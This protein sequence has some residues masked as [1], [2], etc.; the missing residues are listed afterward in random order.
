MIANNALE[1]LELLKSD[2]AAWVRWRRAKYAQWTIDE[3][4][5]AA[6]KLQDLAIQYER[7]RNMQYTDS[8]RKIR[9]IFAE[10]ETDMYAA[11]Q[12][13][14]ASGMPEDEVDRIVLERE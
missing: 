8:E 3:R 4:R 12:I 1:N 11:R 6:E 14:L 13:L 7:E 5:Y 2:P 9:Q 10:W